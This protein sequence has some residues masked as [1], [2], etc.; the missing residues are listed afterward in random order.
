M[1]RFWVSLAILTLLP[2]RA[3]SAV[4]I[5]VTI[6]PLQLIAAEIA[7]DAGKVSMLMPAN[8]SAH[9]YAMTP[10][11][12]VAIENADLLVYVGAELEITLHTFLS[13]QAADRPVLQLMSLPAVSK[14]PLQF[15]G[16]ETHAESRMDP[17][18]WLDTNNVIAIGDAIRAQLAAIDPGNSASYEANS[19]RLRQTLE[20]FERGTRARLISRNTGPYLVYHNAIAYFEKQF[21]LKHSLALLADDDRQPGIRQILETRE[22]ISSIQP[23]CLYSDPGSRTALIN[24]FTAGNPVAVIPLD[25]MGHALT[26][27]QGIVN[28]LENL[29]DDFTRCN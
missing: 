24:T 23:Q 7:G 26:P 5:V 14:I 25:I 6:K 29:V 1:T 10:A 18:I 8:G 11:D 21:G 17:H 9:H 28:L 19:S 20:E 22:A 15:D 4:D 13:A 2:I 27:T 16:P 12:R 3:F